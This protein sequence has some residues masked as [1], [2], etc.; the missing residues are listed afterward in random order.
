MRAIKTG[1]IPSLPVGGAAGCQ[2][3]PSRPG[4]LDIG[5]VDG[6]GTGKHFGAVCAPHVGGRHDCERK[7]KKIAF[8]VL[9]CAATTVAHAD[10]PSDAV[11]KISVQSSPAFVPS[12]VYDDGKFTYIQL[13]KPYTGALPVV[14][15]VA[16]DG[17]REVVNFKW[18]EQNSRLIVMGL[19]DRA[20]LVRG[21]EVVSID[22]S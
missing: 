5:N 6:V 12:K 22:H 11:Y 2:N 20:V 19:L 18:D 10:E 13:Q 17:S 16:A 14:S 15:A 4:P 1:Y 7:M 9:L 21:D 8:T 3:S